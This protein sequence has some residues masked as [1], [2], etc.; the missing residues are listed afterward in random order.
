MIQLLFTLAFT[1]ALLSKAQDRFES[2]EIITIKATDQAHMLKESGGNVLIRT[3]KDKV[4][5]IG[6][7]Y[8]SWSKKIKKI[9]SDLTDRPVNFLIDINLIIHLHNTHKEGGSF[10]YLTK[11][12]L[13]H[14]GGIFFNGRY[15]YIDLPSGGS[16]TRYI[17]AQKQILTNINEKTKIFTGRGTLATCKELTDDSNVLTDLKTQIKK[18]IKDGESRKDMKNNSLI[19]RKYDDSGYAD[20]YIS[21]SEI[22]TTIYDSLLLESNNK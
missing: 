15:P 19:T 14:M 9:L 22:R 7:H 8:A 4:V 5:M 3:S 11:S 2:V 12:N 1:T 16:I 13:V 17:A 18:G 20:G 6:S 21:C 10:V